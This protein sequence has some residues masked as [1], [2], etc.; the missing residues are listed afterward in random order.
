MPDK[1]TDCIQRTGRRYLVASIYSCC[2]AQ[3]RT[4]F[5]KWHSPDNLLSTTVH[6]RAHDKTDNWHP[7]CWSICAGQTS[8]CT[9]RA[10]CFHS[11]VCTTSASGHNS[12]RLDRLDM[13]FLHHRRLAVEVQMRPLK[14]NLRWQQERLLQGRVVRALFYLPFLRLQVLRLLPELDPF[15]DLLNWFGSTANGQL[16]L[17]A[18]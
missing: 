12:S 16:A 2:S 4:N 9:S 11:R 18:L 13:Y 5:S 1:K 17:S 8:S 14:A 7:V 10:C 3:E 6:P 15:L